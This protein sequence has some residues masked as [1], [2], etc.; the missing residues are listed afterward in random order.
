MSPPF[1]LA[2]AGFVVVLRLAQRALAAAASLARVAGEKYRPA[3]GGPVGLGAELVRIK[4]RRFS[5]LSI[6]RRIEIAQQ[7]YP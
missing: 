4:E 1:C 6:C 3:C 5:K 2:R 7:I